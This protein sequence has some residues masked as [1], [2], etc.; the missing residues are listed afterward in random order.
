MIGLC[1]LSLSKIGRELNLSC[2]SWLQRSSISLLSFRVRAEV[3][4]IHAMCDLG[5]FLYQFTCSAHMPMFQIESSN[6]AWNWCAL[7]C[8]QCRRFWLRRRRMTS[9]WGNTLFLSLCWWFFF[10][11]IDQQIWFSLVVL[12]D[13]LLERN[14]FRCLI[15]RKRIWSII[16]EV[17]WLAKISWLLMFTLIVLRTAFQSDL[18]RNL[19]NLR[20]LHRHGVLTLVLGKY[21]LV[22]WRLI[23]GD[24]VFCLLSICVAFS[25]LSFSLLLQKHWWCSAWVH[26]LGLFLI[27]H[28]LLNKLDSCCDLSLSLLHLFLTLLSGNSLILFL[29]NFGRRYHFLLVRRQIES[30]GKA[31]WFGFLRWLRISRNSTGASHLLQ[32]F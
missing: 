30:V 12:I 1:L 7:L 15:C 5:L 3:W 4:S 26:N 8:F 25:I 11:I 2:K 23:N 6:W 32:E 20:V 22:K 31:M 19:A 27:D 16:E 24:L 28:W 17:G 21:S 10:I 13:L 14:Y 9:P 18:C 29:V